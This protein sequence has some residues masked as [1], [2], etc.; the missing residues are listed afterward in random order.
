MRSRTLRRL[1]VS[2][3]AVVCFASAIIRPVTAPAT[4]HEL[5][6]Y[7]S[8][9][10][11]K[12][13]GRV[14]ASGEVFDTN[15]MTAAHRTLPFDTVVEVTHLESSRAVEVRIN[16]RGPFVEGR[17]IDLSRA[18]ADALGMT[19]EG[20]AQVRLRVLFLPDPPTHLVQVASFASSRNARQLRDQLRSHGLTAEIE[21]T[22]AVYRVVVPGLADDEIEPVI[23][24]LRELGHPEVLVRVES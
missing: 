22:G 9:Y 4:D 1:S 8:W 6:G 24:K 10:A 2:L 23:R 3:V 11:G 7:A 16:D 12:F 15:E 5:D 18:A 21:R 14:T 17:V 13:Q 19:G 20:I